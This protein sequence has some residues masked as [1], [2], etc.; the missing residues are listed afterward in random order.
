MTERPTAPR[1]KTT[2]LDPGSTLQVFHT[3]PHPVEIPHPSKH[4]LFKSAKG[5]ILA[6]DI[7]ANTVYSENE[8]H[9]IK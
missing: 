1:P 6:T 7:S 2:I 9:P 5:F 8:E 3:A 4:T